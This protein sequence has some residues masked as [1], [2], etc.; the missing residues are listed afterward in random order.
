MKKKATSRAAV[1]GLA[2]LV[3]F[4]LSGA[5]L[6]QEM[7]PAP[8]FQ[9]ADWVSGDLLQ[10][11]SF[12]IAPDVI[13]DGILSHYTIMV[14]DDVLEVA[15]THL[16]GVR[17]QELAAVEAMKQLEGT[18]QFRKAAKNSA[19][20][21]LSFAIDLV[22]SPIDTGRNVIDGVGMFFGS[23]GHS[24]FGDPS[25]EEECVLKTM[26]GFDAAKRGLAA[27]FNVDLYSSNRFLQDQLDD[28]SWVTLAGGLGTKI[29]LSFIPGT[30]GKVVKATSFSKG[31]T[32]L[33]ITKT[34]AEFKSL[35]RD[36]LLSVG[37]DLQLVEASLEHPIY[38]PTRKTFIVGA[39]EQMEGAENRQA[40]LDVALAAKTATDA[41]LWQ[42]KAE[43][44]TAYHVTVK[45]VVRLVQVVTD[46]GVLSASG[47]IVGMIPND[48][49]V[50]SDVVAERIL[51]HSDRVAVATDQVV[52]R[53]ARELWFA[54]GFS[55][56]ARSNLEALGWNVVA[57]AGGK[58]RLL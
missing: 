17:L 8:V 33:M 10:S 50:W 46:D 9:A 2:A 16:P 15:G 19:K 44:L 1:T 36:K 54:G 26:I 32:K 34:P 18:E 24:M 40:L 47:K 5:A 30:A 6:G 23:I 13:N 57:D 28:I 31:M 20:G 11:D 43:M 25:E 56:L 53:S 3:G 12:A 39:L 42:R 37:A 29:A 45:P 38:S 35:N 41:Y 4:M 7:E 27:E 52:E 49:V 55:D 14:D 51:G 22:T 48:Y 21:P 58:L